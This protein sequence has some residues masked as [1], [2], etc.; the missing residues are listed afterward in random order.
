[1]TQY[2]KAWIQCGFLFYLC[3]LEGAIIIMSHKYIF[4]TRFFGRNVVKVLAT[5]FLVC[6]AKMIDIGIS[7][8]EFAH[9]RY[10]EGPNTVVWLFDGNVS[11]CSGKHIPLFVFGLTFC[12]F[13]LVYTM[14]LLF[15]QCLQRRSNVCCLRWVELNIKKPGFSVD[16]SSIYAFWKVQLLL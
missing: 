1:M 2:Q 6:C 7:S 11:Y 15:I 13:A 10:S 9:I 4:F 12:S 14:T 16:F 3:I 8:L 5:L